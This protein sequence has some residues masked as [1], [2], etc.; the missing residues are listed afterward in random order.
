MFRTRHLAAAISAAMLLAT[1]AHAADRP[2]FSNVV[3]FGDSLSDNGNISTLTPGSGRMRFTT[4]PGLVSSELVA[5][6]YGFTLEPSTSGGTDYAWGGSQ[7]AKDLGVVV[8]AKTQVNQYLAANGGRADSRAL[9]TMWIGANDILNLD[10]S[11]DLNG[12]MVAAANA[13]VSTLKTLQHA[14]R[15]HRDPGH[16]HP[17]GEHLRLAQPG[18][19]RSGTLRF[20][21]RD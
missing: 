18:D 13:E 20:Q 9:Y 2:S 21:Q 8:S 5:K 11:K 3:V 1:A 17:A 7:S 4:N 10:F 12:Q 15:R 6:H 14:Q 16:G 19:R